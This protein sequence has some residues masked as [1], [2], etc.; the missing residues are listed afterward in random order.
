[1]IRES[2]ADAA[3]PKEGFLRDYVEYA[4]QCTD[5]NIAYHIVGGLSVLAQAIPE[6]IGFPFGDGPLYGNFYG[7]VVGPSTESRKSV[8]VKI[9]ERLLKA[10]GVGYIAEQPGSH[11]GLSDSVR[12]NPKQIVFYDEFGFFLSQTEKGYAVPLKTLYTNLYDSGSIGR[13]LSGKRRGAV[14]NPRVSVL[15][16]STLDFLERHTDPQDWTGGF[17]ARFFTIYADRE[18]TFELPPP[19]VLGRESLVERLQRLT[20]LGANSASGL[21]Q[22][23]AEDCVPLWKDWYRSSEKQMR[24]SAQETRAAVSRSHAMCLKIALLLAWDGGRPRTGEEWWIEESEL[25]PAIK[26][27]E[28]HIRSALEI[29]SKLAATREMRDHNTVLKN[30]SNV[31]PRSLGQIITLSKV[32]LRRRV[33]EILQSLEEEGLVQRLDTPDNR[34]N[35]YIRLQRTAED[36]RREREAVLTFRPAPALADELAPA[37]VEEPVFADLEPMDSESE[38]E[39][40]SQER[41]ESEEPPILE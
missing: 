28:L 35:Y 3:I 20:D 39:S 23:L 21:C 36:E 1:M 34:G 12:A 8:A 37:G 31:E 2:E 40:E 41:E 27:T 33:L 14:D 19:R 13:A 17:L 26:M 22:G 6:M 29:G 9:A 30:L 11:E 7:L 10:S 32:G 15:G 4:R 16:G 24:Q 5:A 25:V 38:S 18:R